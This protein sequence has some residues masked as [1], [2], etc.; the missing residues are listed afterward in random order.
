MSRPNATVQWLWNGQILKPDTRIKID[1]YDVVR[2]LVLSGLQPSDSGKYICDAI[3]DKLITVVEVQG[4]IS[5]FET[6]FKFYFC[7]FCLVNLMFYIS[8]YNLQATSLYI[9]FFP[10][11]PA[12][13]V[14]KKANNVI[15]A[16]EN[17]SVTLCAI[18]SHER[19]NVRWLKDG[20]L[21]NE[22]NIHIS[23]EGNTHKLTINPLQLSDS[24]EYVCDVNTDEMYFSLLVKGKNLA[25]PFKI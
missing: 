19:A 20:Q 21:L 24:G 12:K 17:E 13:F 15:S 10:E 5:H 6:C 2:K 7:S 25:L 11:L 4:K 14:N 16:S 1:S 3:D 18:V 9:I 23:S 8:T 22:D